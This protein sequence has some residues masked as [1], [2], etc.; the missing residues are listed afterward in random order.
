MCCG[1]TSSSFSNSPSRMFHN[2]RQYWPVDSIGISVTPQ[3]F[4]QFRSCRK[5]HVNVGK[6]RLLMLWSACPFGGQDA[7]HSHCSCARRAAAPPLWSFFHLLHS[8]LAHRARDAWDNEKTFLCVFTAVAG[9]QF[10]VPVS[11]VLTRI[12]N[13]LASSNQISVSGFAGIYFQP[14]KPVKS[15]HF[16][17]SSG[18]PPKGA[19]RRITEV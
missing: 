10:Q 19:V 1:F 17:P 14:P 9:Q 11:C 5:S 12:T 15:P 13:G 16:H 8:S 3:F 6:L 18:R 4:S 2:G 7:K